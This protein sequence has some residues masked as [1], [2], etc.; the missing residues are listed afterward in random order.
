L[1]LINF[2]FHQE[3]QSMSSR[4]GWYFRAKRLTHGLSVEALARLVG[5][6]NLRKG[7]HRIL[8]FEQDGQVPDTL[9]V[10]LADALGIRYPT[11]FDLMDRDDASPLRMPFAASRIACGGSGNPDER[12]V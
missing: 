6:R 3:E 8:R 2:T 12:P 4:L 9:I 10:N 7:S 5:Y 1:S 11:I